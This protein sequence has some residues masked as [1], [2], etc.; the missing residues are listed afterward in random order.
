M[1]VI[2]DE[3]GVDAPNGHSCSNESLQSHFK[4]ITFRRGPFPPLQ[5]SGHQVRDS[6]TKQHSLPG[7]C[8]LC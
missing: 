7:D 1:A 8:E 2:M 3:S 4:T 6:L 5:S